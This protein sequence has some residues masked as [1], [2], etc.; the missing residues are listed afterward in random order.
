MQEQAPSI[1]EAIGAAFAG[2][3]AFFAGL[4]GFGGGDGDDDDGGGGPELPTE[5]VEAVAV[6]AGY[7]CL[8]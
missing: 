2:V 3:G 5:V 7:G 6:G 8:P 1:L 4:V